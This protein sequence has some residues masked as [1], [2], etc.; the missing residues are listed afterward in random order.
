MTDHYRYTRLRPL[1]IFRVKAELADVHGQR[2]I[3][4]PQL[5]RYMPIG[6]IRQVNC[7]VQVLC[8]RLC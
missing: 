1:I 3:N 4:L 2:P 8:S 7:D 5:R 6:D